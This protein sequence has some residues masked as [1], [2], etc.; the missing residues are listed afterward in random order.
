V[1]REAKPSLF[2]SFSFNLLLSM[3][4]DGLEGPEHCFYC[5][6]NELLRLDDYTNLDTASSSM[7]GAKVPDPMECRNEWMKDEGDDDDD[8]DDEEEEEAWDLGFQTPERCLE[9]GN[10]G[11]N[12][13]YM[14]VHGNRVL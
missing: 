11:H 12:S 3:A 4:F 5:I 14:Y 10:G 7:A 13:R 9:K 6:G 2:L 8:D 1:R